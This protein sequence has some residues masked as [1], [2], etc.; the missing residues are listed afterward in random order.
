M[1]FFHTADLH[2][3]KGE[4]KRME[5]L[6]WLIQ[7]AE[8]YK[9]D[10]FIIAGDLFESDTDATQL[11]PKIRK[12]F[13]AASVKFI[14]LPGNHDEKSFSTRYDYGNNVFQ[15]IQ[16]PF[17]VIELS[18]LTICGV[19][20]QNKRFSECIKNIPSDID[21][22]IAH[23]TLYDESFIFSMLEDEETKYMPM[24]PENL[25][26]SARY[27]A[28]GHLHS[29]NI[30]KKY[31]NTNVVYPGSPIALDTKCANPRFIYCVNID[32]RNLSIEPVEIEISPYWLEKEFFVFPGIEQKIIENIESYLQKIDNKNVMPHV[33]VKGYIG[34]KDKAFNNAARV[35]EDKFREQFADIRIHPD[36]ES[37]DK[38]VQNTMV[39][40]FIEKTKQ[41]DDTLRL[42]I[43]EITFPIFSKAIK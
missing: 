17:E 22:I 12:M 43:F 23:G 1:K 5:I 28:L 25:E 6:K 40:T 2:L 30:E 8:E 36:V 7:K 37:W 9:V 41:F 27:V 19:P 38:L 32:D 18:G 20:Y 35:L 10:F 16:T 24:Y 33:T 13:E 34:E 26:H 11:R 42:K 15:L 39:K 21:I 3:K 4:A 14:I 31:K 29:R